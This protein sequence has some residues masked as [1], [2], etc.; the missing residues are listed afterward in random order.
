V[1]LPSWRHAS[2][3]LQQIFPFPQWCAPPKLLSAVSQAKAKANK[4]QQIDD[5]LGVQEGERSI[6]PDRKAE[7]QKK[8]KKRLEA[9]KS[10]PSGS[11]CGAAV[12]AA[13]D[14]THKGAAKQAAA[15]P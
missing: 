8:L 3:S 12:H 13:R 5:F 2:S 11:G 4:R 14:A 9:M 10:A 6:D 7:G 1:P 15:S